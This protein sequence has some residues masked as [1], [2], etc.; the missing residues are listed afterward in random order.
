[1]INIYPIPAFND[2]Y[3]WLIRHR[4][5]SGDLKSVAVVDPGDANP[6]LTVLAQHGLKLG[7]ILITHHHWDHVDGI[8]PL[9]EQFPDVHVYGP[10]NS[11]VNTITHPIKE[12]DT[13]DLPGILGQCTVIETPGHTLDHISYL[14]GNHLFC[15]DTLFSAGCGRLFEGSAKQM[16][17]SL[18]K[19]ARLP[20]STNMYPAHEYTLANL[21]FASQA[22]A[23]N[24]AIA[25]RLIQ[26]KQLRRQNIPSVPTTIGQ[27]LT[28]NP[29][30]RCNTPG[31]KQCVEQHTKNKLLT[32]LEVFTELRLWKDHS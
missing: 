28:T 19:L 15:G 31:V 32:S 2:N 8:K 3:I 13:F 17:N 26:V 9:R 10:S 6:V 30:L 14:V 22:D 20:T 21:H 1:M 16:F 24:D 18:N 27:E 29:F 11:P 5:T 25:Q 23:G 7:A 12:G 4:E